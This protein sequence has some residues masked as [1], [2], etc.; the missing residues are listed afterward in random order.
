VLDNRAGDPATLIAHL[1][2]L[3]GTPR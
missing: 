3:A 1:R 2:E